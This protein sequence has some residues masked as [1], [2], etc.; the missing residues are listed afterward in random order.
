MAGA[1]WDGLV[2][3]SA[4]D[5]RNSFVDVIN[6]CPSVIPWRAKT[7]RLL[8]QDGF[9][10]G[11]YSTNSFVVGARTNACHG[12]DLAAQSAIRMKSAIGDPIHFESVRPS[13]ESAWS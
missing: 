9:I 2:H 5:M 4:C 6:L 13:S 7:E 12:G 1:I 11:R 8:E 3:G 10:L